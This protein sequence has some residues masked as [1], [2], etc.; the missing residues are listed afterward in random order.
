MRASPNLNSYDGQAHV[1]ALHL[2][3]LETVLGFEEAQAADLLA[4]V[5]PPGV[6]GSPLQLTVGP[7][8]E[9][10]VEE[11][12]PPSARQ[13]GIVADY[14]R[15]SGDPPG[16]RKAVVPARCG[17]FRT[18]TVVLSPRDLLVE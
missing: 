1:V 6:T 17:L 2:F 3:P 5:M 15:A 4:G 12:L 11:T 13:L 18:P 10:G 9:R 8:E 16:T 7:G 14:Y